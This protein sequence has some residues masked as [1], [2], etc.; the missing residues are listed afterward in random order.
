M[1]TET[2]VGAWSMYW[3]LKAAETDKV[4]KYIKSNYVN[5]RYFNGLT[6]QECHPHCTLLKIH[7][8]FIPRT[9]FD[10]SMDEFIFFFYLSL[11]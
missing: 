1:M 8:L 10:E 4:S 3:G 11:A 5:L 6:G 2:S 9:F 7:Y